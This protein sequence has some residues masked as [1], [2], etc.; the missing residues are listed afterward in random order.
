MQTYTIKK[1][2][3]LKHKENKKHTQNQ[4]SAVFLGGKQAIVGP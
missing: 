1:K 2:K 3:H 4:V